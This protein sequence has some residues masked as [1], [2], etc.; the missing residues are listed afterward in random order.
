MILEGGDLKFRGIQSIECRWC[1]CE[2]IYN[3]VQHSHTICLRSQYLSAYVP[4]VLLFD[5]ECEI[6]WGNNT[7]STC[8]PIRAFKYDANN[9]KLIYCGW[10]LRR[11]LIFTCLLEDKVVCLT[12]ALFVSNCLLNLWSFLFDK[13]A[14]LIKV[15]IYPTTLFYH[16][17]FHTSII[18]SISCFVTCYIACPCYYVLVWWFACSQYDLFI[19]GYKN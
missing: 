2:G 15:I 10:E 1:R 5:V 13:I 16:F 6:V 3:P 4:I 12:Y 8:L 17:P 18:L 14:Q 11:Q 9:L 19:C 7:N